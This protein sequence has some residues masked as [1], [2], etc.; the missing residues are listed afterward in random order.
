VTEFLGRYPDQPNIRVTYIEHPVNLGLLLTFQITAEI[1]LKC[2]ND[3]NTLTDKN[4][5][6]LTPTGGFSPTCGTKPNPT[7]SG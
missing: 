2:N 4:Y 6:I 1:R 7:N 3:R 5:R